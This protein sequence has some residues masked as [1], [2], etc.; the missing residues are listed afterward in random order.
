[1]VNVYKSV[2][3]SRVVVDVVMPGYSKDM[4]TVKTAK[5]SDG[6]GGK[7]FVLK[8]EGTYVRPTGKTGKAVPRF[9]YDKVIDDCFK[10]NPLDEAGVELNDDYDVTKVKYTVKNGVMR[11]SIPKTVDAIGNKL[12]AIADTDNVDIVDTA[13][14]DDE[15]TTANA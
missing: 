10:I 1:M 5:V 6:N 2:T 12:A 3:D 14:S 7:K 9:A 11:I 13:A 8:V 4:V 15:D